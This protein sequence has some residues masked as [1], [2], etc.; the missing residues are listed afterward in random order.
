MMCYI[1]ILQFSRSPQESE[2]KPLDLKIQNFAR[3][4]SRTIKSSEY[5]PEIFTGLNQMDL[6]E[7]RR[8]KIW[9]NLTVCS[10][11]CPHCAATR[12]N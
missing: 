6:L 10:I 2:P 9:T 5:A 3:E 1:I 8:D 7:D 11:L 4:W 12:S